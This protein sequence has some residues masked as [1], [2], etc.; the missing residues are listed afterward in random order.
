MSIKDNL[1]FVVVTFES[2][3]VIDA[4]GKFVIP[5]GIDPHTHFDMPFGGTMS[6]DDFESDPVK[7][8]WSTSL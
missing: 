5:G 7:Q 4:N 6:A 1:T 2:D 3:K 8:I